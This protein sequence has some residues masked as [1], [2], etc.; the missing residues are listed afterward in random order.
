MERLDKI[1]ASQTNYSRKEVKDLIK[2][3]RVRVNN[4][5]IAKS[6]I[7]VDSENDK[8]VIDEREIIIKKHIY[9]ILNKPKGYISATEDRSMQTVLDLVPEEYSHRN[10]FPAGRLD[11]DT[12]GL[13]LITDDGEF[14]HNILAPKKHVKKLYN[15]TLD[16]LVNQEM[17]NG[18]KNGVILND[19]ECKSAIIEITGTNTALVTLTEGRYHQ[20]KRM[21]GCYGAK[22]VEL[23]RIGM[24]NFRLPDD[25]KL[26][27]CRE[28][29]ENEL[30]YLKERERTM[31]EIKFDE[32]NKQSIAIEDNIKIG[33]CDYIEIENS[34]NIVHTEVNALY[35]GQGI[36]RKLVE[37]II[38]NAQKQNKNI[39]AD[40]SY[41]KKVI[42][43]TKK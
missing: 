18:F 25:L 43:N 19:G 13:M 10:L 36:A 29:T 32:N 31:V 11:R 16:I 4:E 8:I 26:G 24:G 33:E 39:I 28:I 34:W 20:I 12:T 21:F 23:Q 17:V 22:V 6:D 27:E 35:K 30:E 14:A 37:I 42:E 15:V 38:E 9:L 2:Q 41:A 3:K 1:I 7:K 5:I 40:C